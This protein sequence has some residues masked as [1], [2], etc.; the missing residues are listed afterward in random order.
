MKKITL[1]IICA[2]MAAGCLSCTGKSDNGLTPDL[3]AKI[4]ALMKEMTLE[5]KIGQ[6]NLL[7][8][9]EITTGDEVEVQILEEVRSG[10]CG[11]ILNAMTLENILEI[12]KAAVEESRLGI[13]VLFGLDVIHGHKTTFPISLAESCSWDLEAIGLSAKTAAREAAANGINWTFAPMVDICVEPRWGR[14]S[15]GAGEDPY[16][17]S[18]VAAARVRGFQG[19]DLSD[20]ETLAACV[21][22][23]AAYGAPHGGR[24]YNTVDMS[25]RWF[26]EFYLPPYKAGI[27]AGAQTI[28]PSFNEFD[29]VPATA[30]TFLL[31]TI[32]REEMGFEGVTVTDYGAIH[33]MTNHG[34]VKDDKEAADKSIENEID[35]DMCSKAYI[36]YMAELI[37]EGKVSMKALDKAVRRI[38][39]LKAKLGL[40]DDPY[41]YCDPERSASE[42]L[43]D[44]NKAAALD[45]ATK[46]AVLLKNDGMLPLKKGEKIA[47]IGALAES[48]YD[49]LGAWSVAGDWKAAQTIVDA[50]KEYN[51]ANNVIYS[52]GCKTNDDD[53][54][55]F[56]RALVS[57][58]QA[59][60]VVMVIGENRDMSGEAASRSD[61]K[62]PGVQSELLSLIAETGKPVAVVLLNGRPLD[63][64]EESK[65]ANAILDVWFPGTMGG[66]AI[67]KLLYG[68]CNPSGKLTITFPRSVGQVPIYYYAKNT[69]RPYKEPKGEYDPLHTPNPKY[70]SRYIDIQNSPLYPF[71]YGLSYTTFAYS[72]MTLSDTSFSKGGS[73][74]VSVT[75]TN[76]GKVA[77]A[78][79]AQLYIRDLV[80][81]V[82]RPLKQLKGFE[83]IWLEAGES[84]TVSFV[85]D[86][87]TISFYRQDMSYGPE[88]GDFHV[89]VGSS[90]NDDDLTRMDFAYN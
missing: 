16:L 64:S 48:Q 41:R 90:S 18:L 1:Y 66:Q 22:H 67:A 32:L 6:T 35:M 68:E 89:F 74:T 29:G 21:K 26:R 27:E 53:R 88:A 71:G 13:P 23:Y 30:N 55:G 79:V 54:T 69:G 61:I 59:D 60:K 9:P 2:V 81:S 80:G 56:F 14:V 75:V 44:A 70:Q 85:I 40:L 20:I 46:S 5:E 84:K 73:I 31:K 17:G 77:G 15:E 58:A 36:K 25:E 62:I 28:M 10:R 83:K 42:T 39:E 34:N 50:L 7:P 76:T 65:T 78:E 86:E 47:V 33:E 8:Y 37:D 24:E 43:S 51:G 82:T 63:L 12:Q 4:D 87:E 49:L 52:E 57:V 19:D 45:V 11:N 72:D 3:N 38:L